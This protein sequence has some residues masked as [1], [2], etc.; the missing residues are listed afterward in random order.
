MAVHCLNYRPLMRSINRHTRTALSAPA[1]PQHPPAL[2]PSNP[3]PQSASLAHSSQPALPECWLSW[4]I[5][6]RMPDSL[7]KHQ[8][9]TGSSRSQQQ[10]RQQQQPS[11]QQPTT[12]AKSNNN[13]NYKPT[14]WS[15]TQ[16]LFAYKRARQRQQIHTHTYTMCVCVKNA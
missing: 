16:Q 8:Q 13:N 2:K 9:P 4:L 10:Q 1:Y 12:T 6:L 7:Y 14:E 3:K 15:S 11:E 5:R